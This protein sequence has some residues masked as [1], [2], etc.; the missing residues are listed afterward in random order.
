MPIHRREVPLGI[1]IFQTDI[2]YRECLQSMSSLGKRYTNHLKKVRNKLHEEEKASREKIHILEL[3]RNQDKLETPLPGDKHVFCGVCNINYDNYK[4]HIEST[5][6]KASVRSE[7]LYFEIDQLID[8]FQTKMASERD[9]IIE[10]V[11][12][13][14]P[15]REPGKLQKLKSMSIAQSET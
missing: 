6:H 4:A 13:R 1:S 5:S 12:D 3:A 2:E 8:E 15:L 10:I 11:Q 7:D 14:S 9:T